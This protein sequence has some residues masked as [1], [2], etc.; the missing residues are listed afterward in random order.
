MGLARN[1]LH[2]D[3]LQMRIDEKHDRCPRL[4]APPRAN[5][6]VFLA[7]LAAVHAVAQPASV[8]RLRQPG[9]AHEFAFSSE[10]PLYLNFD[11]MTAEGRLR[12]TLTGPFGTPI[13]RWSF[14]SS[15][16]PSQSVLSLGPGDYRLRIDA[17]DDFTGDYAFRLSPLGTGTPLTPGVNQSGTLA[18]ANSTALHLFSPQAGDTYRLTV[19]GRTNLPAFNVAVID[20]YGQTVAQATLGS[21]AEFTTRSASPYTVLAIG[22]INNP[23][24]N[25]TYGLALT[26]LANAPLYPTAPEL[27]L[28]VVKAADTTTPFT[29]R[30]RFTKTSTGPLAFNP[31]LPVSGDRWRIEGPAGTAGDDGFTSGSKI[32][33][34][35]PGDYLVTI[36]RTQSGSD[37]T[38]FAIHDLATSPATGPGETVAVTNRPAA[39]NAYFRLPLTTGQRVGVLADSFSGYPQSRPRLEV[40]AP[41]GSPLRVEQSSFSSSFFDLPPFSATVNGN[42]WIALGSQT[43]EASPEGMRRFSVISVTE[44]DR[45]LQL[46]AE[47]SG[48]IPTPL[49]VV[50]ARFSLPTQRRIYLDILQADPVLWRL[51][52]PTGT[53]FSGRFD[54]KY[55]GV[56]DLP[57]G[58][59]RLTL[60]GSDRETPGYRFRLLDLDAAPPLALGTSSTTT[61]APGSG[62]AAYRL[63]LVPGQVL[64]GRALQLDGFGSERPRW[65]LVDPDGRT[66]WNQSFSDTAIVT[67]LAGG[68]HSLLVQG[69]L[70]TTNPAPSHSLSVLPVPR[71]EAPLVFDT[72]YEERIQSPGETVAYRFRLDRSMRI[73]V[74]HLESSDVRAELSGPNGTAWSGVLY[75]DGTWQTDLRPGDYRLVFS[76]INTATPSFRF[77]VLDSEAGIATTVGVTNAVQFDSARGSRYLRI[78][79]EAGQRIFVDTLDR[80]GFTSLPWVLITGPDGSTLLNQRLGD[81]GPIRAATSGTYDILLQGGIDQADSAA[82]ATFAIRQADDTL[83]SILP[84]SVVQAAIAS[85]GERRRFGWTQAED[86][87]V[88]IDSLVSSD[89]GWTLNTAWSDVSNG[90]LYQDSS[91]IFV[92]AGPAE[93]VVT[94]SQDSTPAFRFRVLPFSSAGTVTL[95]TEVVAE[96]NPSSGASVF[97]L[98]LQAGRKITVRRLATTGFTA[99]PAWS[100]FDP[101]GSLVT[102]SGSTADLNHTATLEGRYYLVISGDLGETGAGGTVRY[103]VLDG[104]LTPPAPFS[105]PLI[106]FGQVVSGSLP[107]AS[108]SASFRLD[109]TRRT[110]VALD[111]R[112]AGLQ[113]WSLR[114]RARTVANGAFLRDSDNLSRSDLQILALP[115]GEYEMSIQGAAGDYQFVWIDGEAVPLVPPNAP[116]EIVHT[117]ATAGQVFAFNGNAGQ[118]WNFVG[119]PSSGFARRP[120]ATLWSPSGRYL[121]YDYLD[122][123]IDRFALPESG[124]YLLYIGGYTDEPEAA[125]TNR[126][127]WYFAGDISQSLTLNVPVDVSL[128]SPGLQARFSFRLAAPRK[129]VLDALSS[130]PSMMATVDSATARVF[131]ASFNNSD[132]DA[133][134]PSAVMNLGAGEYTLT[135]D[136]SGTSSPTFRFAL[137]DLAT[138]R[139]ISA[140]ITVTGTNSPANASTFYA[141]PVTAGESLL[142]E[143]LGSTGYTSTPYIDLFWPQE[144]G[145]DLAPL[146]S[147]SSRTEVTQSGIATF[148]I[149]GSVNSTA[150]EATHQFRVW[151]V[152]DETRPLTLGAVVSGQ[153]AQPSQVHRWTFRLS[154]PRV[155]V[156]D[157]LSNSAV[158]VRLSGPS[159]TDLQFQFRSLEMSYPQQVILARPGDYVL[160]LSGNTT[161]MPSYQFRLLDVTEAPLVAADIVHDVQFDRPL[162]IQV[163]RFRAN[164]GESFYYDIAAYGGFS[165]ATYVRLFNP[166]G[167]MLWDSYAGTEPAPFVAPYTGDYFL[168]LNASDFTAGSP[169][170]YRFRFVLNPTP[171]PDLLLTG[172]ALADLVPEQVVASPDP[173]V[174]GQSLSVQ[175][176]LANR[177]NAA[178]PT[179]FAD[180][181]SVRNAAGAVIATGTTTDTSGPLAPGQSRLRKFTLRLPDGNLATGP[182]SVEV[183]TD[184]SGAVREANPAGSGEGNNFTAV[185]VTGLLGSYPDLTPTV[186]RSTTPNWAPG[187]AVS[188]EWQV[189]NRG[190]NATVGSWHERLV[191]SNAQT[192]QVVLDLSFPST[193]TLLP[194]TEE[195]RTHTFTLPTGAAGYGTFHATLQIDSGDALPEFNPAGTGELNNTATFTATSAVDLAVTTVS[196]PASIEPG[197]TFPVIHSSTNRSDIAA[198]AAWLDA[199]VLVD[200]DGTE[201]LI[202]Q[203]PT[204]ASI[205]PHGSILTTNFVTLPFETEALTFRIAVAVDSGNALPESDETNNRAMSEAATVPKALRLTAARNLIREDAV[206]PTVILTLTRNGPVDLALEAQVQSS[207]TSELTAPTFVSIP[208]GRSFI[209]FPA[210][211][212]PD[213]QTDGPQGV[214]LSATAPGFRN[215]S[216]AITVADADIAQLAINL[217]TNRLRE[218]TSISATV[219]RTPPSLVAVPIQ[220]LASDTAQLAVPGSV[221]IP[222]G[223]TS[224]AF[225][226]SAIDDDLIERTNL[227]TLTATSPGT[228]AAAASVAVLDNDVPTVTLA[229][230][231]RTVSEGAGANATAATV[232]RSPVSARELIVS[233]AS[234]NSDLV[235]LPPT[236]TIPA[237]QASTTIPVATVDNNTAEGPR[238][239]VIGGFILDSQNRGVAGEIVPDVLTVTD[240]DGPTLTVKLASDAVREGLAVAT[241]GTVWRNVPSAAS[242][243]VTLASSD[244]SEATVP[245]TVTIPAGSATATFPIASVAD[246]ATDGT[247][248]VL[249]TAS[250]AGFVA[251]TATLVVSD[252]DLPDLAVT[253]IKF[254]TTGTAGQ[255][256]PVTI[257]VENLGATAATGSIVQRLSISSD[258][259]AGGDTLA[260]QVSYP[261][262]LPAGAFFEQTINVR[263]PDSP[264]SYY[265][266]AATDVAGSVAEI[267]ESNNL[268]VSPGA[269]AVQPAYTATVETDVTVAAAGAPVTLRGRT[270]KPDGS[271]A[272]LAA[273]TIHVALR[274]TTR[275][276]PVI[277]GPDGA[278]TAVF[279]PLPTEGGL[280]RIAASF[281]GQPMPAAQDEFRLLGIAIN[282]IQR[283]TVNEGTSIQVSTLIRNLTD[284]ALGGLTAEVVQIHP[285]L[286]ATPSLA[287]TSLAGDGTVQ[288]TIDISTVDTS[289][290]ESDLGI[291]IRTAEG[292]E[293]MI[294]TRVRQE[295]R[296]PRLVATPA[297]LAAAMVR[298]RQTP[299]AISL[300]ND[301]GLDSGPLSVLLP[302]TGWMSLSSPSTINSLPPGS[303]TVITVLLTPPADLPLGDYSS[304][305]VVSGDR[306]SVRIPAAFRAVSDGIGDLAVTTEDEYTY[307]AAGSPKLTNALVVLHDALSGTAV[308]T[309]RTGVDGR[310]LFAQLPEAYYIVTATAEGHGP[311]QQTALVTAGTTTNVTAFLPRETVRYTF[312]VEPTTIE[313]RYTLRVESTFETQVPIPVI[314]IEPAAIDIA[315]HPGEEFQIDVTVRNQ[316]LIAADSVKLDIPGGRAF[317]V[318]PLITD[319]GRLPGGG[320][321]TIPVVVKRIPPQQQA[322]NRDARLAARGRAKPASPTDP[323][324]PHNDDLID[325]EACSVRAQLLWDFLCG[326]NPQHRTQPWTIFDSIGC[327]ESELFTRVFRYE[328]TPLFSQ[329]W[330]P[331]EL[332]AFINSLPPVPFNFAAIPTF[333]RVCRPAPIIGPLPNNPTSVAAPQA[334][335]SRSGRVA[336]ADATGTQP[337][338]CARVSMRLDQSTVLTR[339]AFRAT[340][341]VENDT[342]SPMDSVLVNL[343]VRTPAGTNVTE[344]FGIRPPELEAFSA[345]DGAGGLPARSNGRARWTLIPTLEVAPTN[346]AAVFLVSGTL[347]FRQ[348]GNDVTLPLASAPI[349]VYPQPELLV[350]YFHERDVYAD[351]PFTPEVEPSVPYSLA[352]QL[353]N[354]GFGDARGL[355]LA[356]GRPQ[357]VDNQK[358]LQ[359]EFRTLAAQLENQPLTPALDV[360]FGAIP[361]GTNRLARWL[362]TSTIQ[363]SFTNFAASFE[364]TDA[365][366]GRRLSLVRSVE[367]HDL[368]RLIN[369][370]KPDN[371]GRFD[372]LVNDTADPDR[373]PDTLYLSNGSTAP[374]DAVLDAE[375][376]PTGV[377][378][379]YQVAV[380]PHPR[381]SYVRLPVTDGTRNLT[382]ITRPDGTRIPAEN[383]WQTDR[384]IRG[385]DQRPLPTNLVHFVEFAPAGTYRLTFGETIAPIADT[386][387]PVSSV[388]PLPAESP[389]EFQVSWSGNDGTGSGIAAYDIYRSTDGGA[390]SPWLTQTT[391][392]SALF[393]GEPGRTYAFQSVAIDRAG[394]REATPA[395]P[396]ATTRTAI[397]NRAPVFGDGLN[398]T[399]DEGTRLEGIVKATDPDA[400]QTVTFQVVAGAPPGFLLDPAT[401]RYFWSP[402]ESDGPSAVSIQVRASDNGNP[403]RTAEATL[404]VTVR[405]VNLAPTL[406]APSDALVIERARYTADFVATDPDRPN[407]TLRFSLVSAPDGAVI[408]P[409]T[410][411]FAWRPRADQGGTTYR[412]VARVTDNGTPARSTDAAFNI[413]VRDTTADLLLAAGNSVVANGS[414]GVLPFLL[415][416]PPELGELSFRITLP[417]DRIGVPAIA[418]LAPDVASATVVGV[419]A[420]T[421]EFRLQLRAGGTLLTT[422]NLL[423]IGFGTAPSAFSTR[424]PVTP[425]S[426]QPRTTSG[427]TLDGA[428]GQAGFIVLV[429]ADPL[430]TLDRPLNPATGETVLHVYGPSGLRYTLETRPTA[431]S[432][433][434]WE[435]VGPGQIPAGDLHQTWSIPL[436]EDQAVYRAR[437]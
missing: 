7:F 284:I 304:A 395:G 227:Y 319:L 318:T 416:A 123:F 62:T 148:H 236:A 188:L 141:L 252:A 378:N 84:G 1:P 231:Q 2:T 355:K 358:G 147:Y 220:L 397:E 108:S 50:R 40:F 221:T 394:N 42:Y 341:E 270:A 299:L 324:E 250:A 399:L 151:R 390:Y 100:L 420:G 391:E 191:V 101:R 405:E 45:A 401:G 190:L 264:A 289:A 16:L 253:S 385:G 3:F 254:P 115:P 149:S 422:R 67:T 168:V 302:A 335:G 320:S 33:Q 15:D 106:T 60:R 261:G 166:T 107:D 146:S 187:A 180:R 218:G 232:T 357:V 140:N 198:T 59:W 196:I 48:T 380:A 194:N 175:F 61:H 17:K 375:L 433:L 325:D 127:R 69:P 340:L 334:A 116:Q 56:W 152:V 214:T 329:P 292:P 46:G 382:S 54:S 285:S 184:A 242:L 85:P 308:R 376:V 305:I 157:S 153:L 367:I 384:F 431:D 208:A 183:T 110:R 259:Y 11:P 185:S 235:R 301:G 178:A 351:D 176:N 212:V 121:T 6:G 173:V 407:Q 155:L 154:E 414:T 219:V 353:L 240:N 95:G 39:L 424:L 404:Q 29:N 195:P 372:L 386:T 345:V 348:D 32:L 22:G 181:V 409:A 215:A 30:Y 223:A 117:P 312:T 207:D 369:G 177:G 66:V 333:R 206:D 21:P 24:T 417:A 88:V 209:T 70:S 71:R 310:A 323:F 96:L 144:G 363:G 432:A 37:P 169:P 368:V 213:G 393:R 392:T 132:I 303:N 111:V 388:K 19:N 156:L 328:T 79:F 350:R 130:V 418:A 68:R 244:L 99:A 300:R 436:F 105:G 426:I 273:A 336:R 86:S 64:L 43:Y 298:G 137:R 128:P 164:A 343:V 104:G 150:P 269:I 5:A 365:L 135:F 182:L 307:F 258:A 74:D 276:L 309:N 9:E 272:P 4:L 297:N 427:A 75:S 366:G 230:A 124:R 158:N 14:T 233:L 102:S 165:S 247:Q 18:P 286:K 234:A 243:V 396:D 413:A 314:T 13:D 53:P 344:L 371:D 112:K 81:L 295:V 245:S 26:L 41:D 142:V 263:L 170:T 83:T 93:V 73:A 379:E 282:P 228:P 31:I 49:G 161:D 211:V 421:S 44:E 171:S 216:V 139:P 315:Q 415:N 55:S 203:R 342:D 89:V 122:G 257:R 114:D 23:G 277:A 205:P 275:T 145:L 126:F 346:S 163:R 326:G 256:I 316:G 296:V 317:T 25:G 167:A 410:G 352:V 133:S 327:D 377:P 143:G 337:D 57:P 419:E 200:A 408:D 268:R 262:P 10:S 361:S 35:P 63:Q 387:A 278:F 76:P 174:S 283:P 98:D 249:I 204:V 136:P 374:V 224:A 288:L 118:R 47:L 338:V 238:T 437:Y 293:A 435:E 97:A 267:L 210:Q 281:P 349:T 160:A 287:A 239:V 78:P 38:R 411:T 255:S 398:V 217:S 20:P 359:I 91:P 362:F 266:V 400:G 94:P 364:H 58:D 423:S 360:E 331:P 306:A 402:T 406:K 77:R 370:G 36:W 131:S 354:V 92:P 52:G 28:G 90:R 412:V 389:L 356:G 138:A 290:I 425:H 274:G 87:F 125:A 330:V 119:E 27:A 229:L 199:I 202:A 82:S 80:S 12:W 271:P 430:L 103:T 225:N 34:A 113:R 322:A 373:L 311:F 339:D 51:D 280:Y 186:F 72:V 159:A 434:P 241:E 8:G 109:I 226:L 313:D 248:S 134:A 429:G 383:L 332:T 428:Q 65:L 179:P 291:R 260:G 201:S 347:S 294:V 120:A 172:Q 189:A 279:Q 403:V 193:G 197:A 381:W 265:F 246:G 192:R 222:A 162:G 237:G 129:L 321:I 251:G